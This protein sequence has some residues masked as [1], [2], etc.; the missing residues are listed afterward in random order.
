MLMKTLDKAKSLVGEIDSLK[1]QLDHRQFMYGSSSEKG[2][3]Q[4]YEE[5]RALQDI[6]NELEQ[7]FL[8]L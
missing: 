4:L 1:R 3:R 2:K 6:I 7:E 5:A 8:D